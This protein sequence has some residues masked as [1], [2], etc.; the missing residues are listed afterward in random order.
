[1]IALI[2][3]YS[4]MMGVNTALESFVSAAFG[5]QNMHECGVYLHRAIFLITLLYL[6]LLVIMYQT[7]H[8]LTAVGIDPKIA[9]YAS[10]YLNSQRIAMI[11]RAVSESIVLY[12]TSM[13]QA[14]VAML[15]QIAIIPFHVLFCW[16]LIP[17]YGINGA[18]YAGNVTGCL[19]LIVQIIYAQNSKKIKEAWFFPTRQTF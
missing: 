1:M 14:T 8:L 3:P 13:N 6:P 5:R 16:F 2:G 15:L 19:T 12:L 10:E 9:F 7:E 17:K 11:T 18:A 4:I